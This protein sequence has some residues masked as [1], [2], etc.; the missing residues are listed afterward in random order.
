MAGMNSGAY[1]HLFPTHYLS[2]WGLDRGG[3]E[4]GRTGGPA[5]E[6]GAPNAY[7][8]LRATMSLFR[9]TL[10]FDEPTSLVIGGGIGHR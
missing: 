9:L 6:A 2:T 7:V 1:I 5:G 10:P 8:C 4:P 3:G